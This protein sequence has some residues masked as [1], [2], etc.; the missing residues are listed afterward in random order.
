MINVTVLTVTLFRLN[1][2][3]CDSADS[4]LLGIR[5]DAAF[6]LAYGGSLH[7]LAIAGDEGNEHS[8]HTEVWRAFNTGISVVSL[9][10]VKAH[11]LLDEERVIYK[12]FL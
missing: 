12:F 5:V 10:D 11:L 4:M 2:H 8:V 9:V 1:R 7:C 3:V 6:C